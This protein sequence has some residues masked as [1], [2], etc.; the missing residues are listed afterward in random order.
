MSL[1][2]FETNGS[3][4]KQIIKDYIFGDIISVVSFVIGHSMVSDILG[5]HKP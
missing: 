1:I 3:N 4:S 5:Q 2:Y